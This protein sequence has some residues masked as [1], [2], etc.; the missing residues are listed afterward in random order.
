MMSWVCVGWTDITV[1]WLWYQMGDP[2]NGNPYDGYLCDF[3]WTCLINHIKH[4]TLYVD[5]SSRWVHI[6]GYYFVYVDDI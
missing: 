5:N 3:G 2:F 1:E 6:V 4:F